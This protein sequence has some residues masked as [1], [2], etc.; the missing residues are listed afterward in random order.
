[1]SDLNEMGERVQ[2]TIETT[3]TH[4]AYSKGKVASPLDGVYYTYY[5]CDDCGFIM[6]GSKPYSKGDASMFELWL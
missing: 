4:A 3:D 5:K 1:M 6:I 2:L